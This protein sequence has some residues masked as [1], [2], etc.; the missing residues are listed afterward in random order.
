MGLTF[1]YYKDYVAND[2][3]P[4]KVS[5]YKTLG[6]A[7]K[8]GRG[9]YKHLEDFIDDFNCWLDEMACQKDGFKPFL[10]KPRK[11]DSQAIVANDLYEYVVDYDAPK[12]SM[13]RK[14]A[15]YKDF[16]AFCN[17]VF[18]KISNTWDNDEQILLETYYEASGKMY[19]LFSEI[20]KKK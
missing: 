15:V 18:E 16:S 3:I 4:E 10:H 9:M 19:E 12:G 17:E 1:K 2:T 7:S 6:L 14:G 5:Y 13:V 8:V 11:D 20:K